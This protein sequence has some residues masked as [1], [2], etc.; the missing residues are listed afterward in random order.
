MF[1]MIEL[2]CLDTIFH[3]ESIRYD[4]QGCFIDRRGTIFLALRNFFPHQSYQGQW[5]SFFP[6]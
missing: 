3:V 6:W 2:S 5:I 1:K 4:G